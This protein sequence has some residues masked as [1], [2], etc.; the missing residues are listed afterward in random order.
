[1]RDNVSIVPIG[2]K[3]CKPFVLDLMVF[4]PEAGF[5]FEVS[6]EKSCAPAADP[7]WKL[8]FDLYQKRDGIDGFDQIVHVSYRANTPSEAQV[9]EATAAN[10][11][12]GEQADLLI[13]NV[14]PAVKALQSLDGLPPAVI[15][16]AKANVKAQIKKV[17][18]LEV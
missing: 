12:S 4:A 7:L 5:R 15:E 14:H 3:A 11:V 2:K 8:V 6:V 10:G 16:Q 9:I 1:M 18:D 17:V 13:N